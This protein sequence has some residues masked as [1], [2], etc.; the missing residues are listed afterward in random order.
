MSVQVLVLGGSY[1]FYGKRRLQANLQRSK[2]NNVADIIPRRGISGDVIGSM[3][4]A[5]ELQFSVSIAFR[6]LHVG[7][8]VTC[9]SEVDADAAE[10]RSW[11]IRC[12]LNVNIYRCN[13]L[14]P[15]PNMLIDYQ[16]MKL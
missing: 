15:L 8:F 3:R 9:A 11:R 10:V 7:D 13:Q 1:Y 5:S 4:D 14:H 16:R 6:T 2:S 12:H